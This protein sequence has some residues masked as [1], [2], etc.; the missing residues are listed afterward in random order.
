MPTKTNLKQLTK[1][2][3]NKIV[4]TASIGVSRPPFK[5]KLGI[6]AQLYR[7]LSGKQQVNLELT[8]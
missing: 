5:L 1:Q 4:S 7:P 6:C 2:Y 8:E 3:A